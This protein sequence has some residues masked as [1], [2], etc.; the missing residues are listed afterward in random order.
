MKTM[1][2]FSAAIDPIASLFTLPVSLA[3]ADTRAIVRTDP[4]PPTPPAGEIHLNSFEEFRPPMSHE[5]IE[6]TQPFMIMND[7]STSNS[8]PCRFNRRSNEKGPGMNIGILKMDHWRG[9]ANG[10]RLAG[11]VTS[12]KYYSSSLTPSRG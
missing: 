3:R 11:F 12:E 6:W 10:V 8:E 9:G 5:M 4:R 1:N 2:L 7:D